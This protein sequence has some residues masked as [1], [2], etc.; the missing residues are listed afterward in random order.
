MTTFAQ[1]LKTARKVAGMTQRELGFAVGVDF[2]QISRYEMA[3]AE[4]RHKVLVGL[5]KALKLSIEQL[6]DGTNDPLAEHMHLGQDLAQDMWQKFHEPGQASEA[7]A[8]ELVETIDEETASMGRSC[9]KAY[10]TGLV[11]HL[12]DVSQHIRAA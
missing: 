4:P 9:K 8:A 12:L 7:V 6:R 3:L 10:M 1:R 11:R 2:T 5:A